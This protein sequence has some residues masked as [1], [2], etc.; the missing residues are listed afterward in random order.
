M[1]VE[2]AARQRCNAAWTSPVSTEKKAPP[3]QSWTASGSA[4]IASKIVAT[5]HVAELSTS[6]GAGPSFPGY[7]YMYAYMYTAACRA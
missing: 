3:H 6:D 2:K 5:L 7:A 4:A 1:I